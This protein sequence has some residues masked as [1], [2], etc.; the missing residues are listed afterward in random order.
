MK[1]TALTSVVAVTGIATA[2]PSALARIMSGSASEGLAEAVN[3]QLE[4]QQAWRDRIHASQ[5]VKRQSIV[6]F[7][8]D[9]RTLQDVKSQGTLQ[10]SNTR[11]QE[12]LVDGT[13]IPEGPWS[14]PHFYIRLSENCFLVTWDAGP[15]WA[16]LL[17][18]SGDHDETRKLF[19][20]S[21]S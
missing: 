16:G 6:Q 13:T 17:P 12:F 19:F 20:W 21:V 10:F 14:S 1:L 2:I 3:F 18:I 4:S 11:T 5:D 8:S 7:S 9:F 15:S